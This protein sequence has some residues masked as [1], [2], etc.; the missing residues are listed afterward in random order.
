MCRYMDDLWR[1][2]HRGKNRNDMHDVR[3]FVGQEGKKAWRAT[4]AHE[5][6]RHQGW[7]PTSQFIRF[8]KSNNMLFCMQAL[9]SSAESCYEPVRLSGCLGFSRSSLAACACFFQMWRSRFAR[10]WCVCMCVWVA[11]WICASH[12]PP[13]ELLNPAAAAAAG[14]WPH[15]KWCNVH[16]CSIG[17]SRIPI[18]SQLLDLNLEWV[19]TCG[20]KLDI[21]I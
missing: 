9:T 18:S 20:G 17:G 3:R 11:G 2:I 7:L 10:S 14:V 4:K 6:I 19:Y 16:P 1:N 5:S 12:P 8:L 15:Y 21:C 13:P